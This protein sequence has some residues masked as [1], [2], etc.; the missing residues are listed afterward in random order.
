MHRET[1]RIQAKRLVVAVESGPRR[2]STVILRR[3]DVV[4]VKGRDG[5]VLVVEDGNGNQVRVK[6][7]HVQL[8]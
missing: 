5:S 2:G 8:Q 1:A 4:E 3:G 6:S 7:K